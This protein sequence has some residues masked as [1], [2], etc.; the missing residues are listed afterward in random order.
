MKHDTPA[1]TPEIFLRTE[2]FI[3]KFMTKLQSQFN[4]ENV[5]N[6][7]RCHITAQYIAIQVLTVIR[8]IVACAALDHNRTSE[9]DFVQT[10]RLTLQ[11]YVINVSS[12]MHVSI[13]SYDSR[14]NAQL[15]TKLQLQYNAFNYVVASLV[16][17]VAT[18]QVDVP[19]FIM[20]NNLAKASQLPIKAFS[21]DLQ[22]CIHIIIAHNGSYSYILIQPN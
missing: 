14:H 17:D 10:A 3:L 21:S 4:C 11:R 19:V 7:D 22:A 9:L 6:V 12:C 8:G 18:H 1:Q 15:Y 2:I 20:L 5:C 16:H 13:C